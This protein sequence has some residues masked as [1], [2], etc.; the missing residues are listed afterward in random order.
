MDEFRG[1]NQVKIK[2]ADLIAK[3]KDNRDSHTKLY[4]DAMEG[5]YVD[6]E[7]KL[8]KKISD[9]KAQKIVAS[10]SVSVP[11]D[12]TPDYDRLIKMLE[13]STDTEL[14]ISSQDF[15]RYV[16]DEWISTEEKGMLRAMALSSSNSEMYR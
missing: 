11:K 10:F 3:L 8:R 1:V 14:V 13:M 12:H 15:N 4:N 2:V 5:Y 6:T 9:L 7:K 16:L